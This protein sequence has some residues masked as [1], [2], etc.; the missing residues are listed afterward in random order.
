[1]SKLL[2]ALMTSAAPPPEPKPSKPEQ[3]SAKLAH[4]VRGRPPPQP[5][6]LP[7][8]REQ[9]TKR[10]SGSDGGDDSD[11]DD[12]PDE[13][14]PDSIVCREFGI[15]SMTL[16]R[17]DHDVELKFPPPIIIRKRKFRVRR[18]LEA[19]KRRMLHRAIEQRAEA[20]IAGKLGAEK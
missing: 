7:K 9:R 5:R 17:W 15:S 16:W 11:G 8:R 20:A 1:M 2:S 10:S 19:F 14:V 3:A 6:E 18:H 13:L 4:N 12:G